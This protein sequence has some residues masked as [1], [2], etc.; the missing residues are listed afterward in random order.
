M[1]REDTTSLKQA[2]LGSSGASVPPRPDARGWVAKLDRGFARLRFASANLLILLGCVSLIAGGWVPWAVLLLALVVGSFA[3]ELGGDDRESL[4][5]RC[6]FCNINLHAT[7]PLVLL[8]AV[9]LLRFTAE[10][11][12]FGQ[13]IGAIY[14]VGYLFALVGA[15]VA[16]ELTHRQGLFAQVSAYILLAF[17]FNTSFV[18]YHLYGHH[19]YVGSYFDP[20]TA[21]RGERPIRHFIPRTI[22]QQFTHAW[23]I[24]A[25]RLRRRGFGP[26]SL[27]T[28]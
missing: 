17:T 19:R 16:H 20:S 9:L 15:T 10:P 14:L 28:D 1:K 23:H 25:D 2:G 27:R 4:N 13:Q 21:R 24:E 5:G 22:V 18:I 6:V 26:W 7:L 11:I 3:D 12:N 8:M